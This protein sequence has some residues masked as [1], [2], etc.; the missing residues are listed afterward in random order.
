MYGQYT[1]DKM[2]F[3]LPLR[4]QDPDTGEWYFSRR[5]INRKWQLQYTRN[6]DRMVRE[7][8]FTYHRAAGST[9]RTKKYRCPGNSYLEITPKGERE[10]FKLLKLKTKRLHQHKYH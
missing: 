7:G 6:A 3:I 10:Y 1:L 8:L 2:A 5:Y 4:N 9:A